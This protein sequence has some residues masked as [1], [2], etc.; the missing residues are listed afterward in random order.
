MANPTSLSN[1]RNLEEY[2]RSVRQAG[3][4]VY[5][6]LT[7]S[8]KS[9]LKHM[10]REEMNRTPPA[11]SSSRSNSN[12]WTSTLEHTAQEL[13]RAKNDK[14]DIID[15]NGLVEEVLPLAHSSIP[16]AVRQKLFARIFEMTNASAIVGAAGEQTLRPS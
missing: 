7:E 8:Q 1:F 9:E 4:R 14:G 2:Q 5:H 15:A 16:P 12:S 3:H 10:L 11:T 13:I 6:H